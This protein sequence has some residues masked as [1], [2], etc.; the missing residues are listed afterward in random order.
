MLSTIESLS[1]D[2][3]LVAIGLPTSK[4]KMTS[5]VDIAFNAS[6]TARKKGVSPLDAASELSDAIATS[7]FFESATNVGAY[8]NMGLNYRSISS[9]VLSEIDFLGSRYGHFSGDGE[10]VIVDFSSPNIAKNMT[11]AHL[12]STV[13]GQSLVKIHQA[14]GDITFGI[15]H[16]GDW[17]SQFGQII[18]MYR[19]ELEERGEEFLDELNANPTATLMRIYRK[20]NEEKKSNPQSIEDAREIFLSLERGDPELIE[21]WSQFR[22]WSLSDFESV[23]QR[24]RVE[25]DAIQG[26]SFYE[27]R[28][29]PAVSEGVEQGVLQLNSD[30]SVVLPSQPLVDSEGKTND[31]LMLD[32]DGQPRDEIIIKPSGGTTYL[33]RDLAA[34]RY[35]ARELGANKILYIIGKEQEVHCIELFNM[36]QQLGYLALG[37]VQHVSFGHLNVDGRKMKSRSGEV[38]L[39]NDLIN[40]AIEAA[41]ADLMRRKSEKGEGEALDEDEHE[42]ARKIGLSA[43]IFNDLSRN[44]RGDIEF[45]QDFADTIASCGALPIQYAYARLRGLSSKLPE[46]LPEYD[47]PDALAGE[48]KAVILEMARLPIVVKNASERN[49]PHELANYLTHLCQLANNFYENCPVFST[50]NGENRVFR[51]RIVKSLQQVIENV[52]DLLHME[53]A[54]RI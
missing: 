27:D 5:S 48:E 8:V 36:A 25:F 7:D 49:I 15:N 6:E 30:S 31:K 11:A 54:G 10:L 26:E 21:L 46:V 50:Q 43:L 39:L 45:G 33:T 42:A 12:R 20:F 34:I 22:R 18:Y 9:E 17:G 44:R 52:S 4:N 23:Y 37:A 1:Y 3:N 13:I 14:A 16:I 32:Q 35:R 41:T 51:A 2:P 53:L 24:L 19:R 47:V 29:R 28:M 38:V 40:T